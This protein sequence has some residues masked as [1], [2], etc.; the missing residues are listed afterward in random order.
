MTLHHGFQSMHHVV[1]MLPRRI[2]TENTLQSIQKFRSRSLANAYG[3]IALNVGMSS[4]G[5]YACA[6]PAD[7][8]A[9]QKQIHELLH[10]LGS[11]KVLSHPHA[12]AGHHAIGLK[13]DFGRLFELR[14]RETGLPLNFRPR[15][16]AEVLAEGVKPG[17]VTFDEI[18]I[19]YARLIIAKR[20]ILGLD[21]GFHHALERGDIAANFHLVVMRGNRRGSHGRHLDQVLR[22]LKA[23]KCSLMQWIEDDDART[24]PRGIAEFRHHPRAIGAGILPE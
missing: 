11:A 10:V 16:S 4:D 2:E 23:F 8:S 14:L 19:Q 21:R 3:T 22:G 7:I 20:T 18:D 17:R 12:I 15:C 24:A 13:V 6:W 9:Q 1:P 5:N